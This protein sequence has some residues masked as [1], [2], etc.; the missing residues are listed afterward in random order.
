MVKMSP[1]STQTL[2]P[3]F[4]SIISLTAFFPDRGKN[5]ICI[6]NKHKLA[7]PEATVTLSR[8]FYIGNSSLPISISK[9]LA[10]VCCKDCKTSNH[11]RTLLCCNSKLS[12]F[13]INTYK[14]QSN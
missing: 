4:P 10:T 1:L 6:L 12:V 14:S 2:A 7:G 8:L 13:L 9:T 5:Y 3:F 11:Q